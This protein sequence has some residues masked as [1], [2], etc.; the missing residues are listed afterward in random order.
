MSPTSLRKRGKKKKVKSFNGKTSARPNILDIKAQNKDLFLS[1]RVSCH[2]ANDRIKSVKEDFNL[3]EQ[4]KPKTS[5]QSLLGFRVRVIN[6]K[7]E[8]NCT[9]RSDSVCLCFQSI[10]Y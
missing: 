5:H 1:Q 7:V 2:S 4:E 8:S 9:T 6:H 3:D 10:L